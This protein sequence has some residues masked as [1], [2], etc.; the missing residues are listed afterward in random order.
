[1]LQARVVT[2]P[3]GIL[4]PALQSLHLQ[5]SFFFGL[6]GGTA[7]SISKVITQGSPP[8][9]AIVTTGS[10]RESNWNTDVVIHVE[11]A[12]LVEGGHLPQLYRE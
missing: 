8:S 9:H 1:V 5:K 3:T 7:Q 2:P 10:K 12:Q 6:L 11:W 4:T